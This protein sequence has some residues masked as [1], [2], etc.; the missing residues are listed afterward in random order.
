MKKLTPI[1]SIVQK[2]KKS[3]PEFDQAHNRSS[4]ILIYNH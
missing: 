3:T 1:A 4:G 2:K